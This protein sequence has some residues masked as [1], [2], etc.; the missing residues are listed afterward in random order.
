MRERDSPIRTSAAPNPETELSAL[1]GTSR[2]GF[3]KSG[4]AAALAQRTE[5]ERDRTGVR[6]LG[7]RR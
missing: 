6:Q 7:L 4:A 5:L 2:R 3:V 1:N